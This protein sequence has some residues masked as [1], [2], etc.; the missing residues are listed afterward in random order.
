MATFIYFLIIAELYKK[1]YFYFV[2]IKQNYNYVHSVE[3][4]SEKAM[5]KCN[6][7]Y[8]EEYKDNVLN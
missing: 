5:R 4:L 1:K 6:C 7:W 2:K 8:W 3:I